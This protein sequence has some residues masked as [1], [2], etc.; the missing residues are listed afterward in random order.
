MEMLRQ[1]EKKFT[2]GWV[3][4]TKPPQK[5]GASTQK[6]QQ[7]RI[8]PHKRFKDSQQF[9]G[10]DKKQTPDPQ[11]NAEAQEMYEKH[12]LTHRPQPSLTSRYVNTPK[13]TPTGS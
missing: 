11:N 4:E 2:K 5:E 6:A 9:A 12:R 10:I 8:P 7:N 3:P 1:E 13:F